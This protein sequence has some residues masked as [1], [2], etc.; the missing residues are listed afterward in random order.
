MTGEFLVVGLGRFGRDLALNLAADRQS[1]LAVDRNRERV[2]GVA[3]HV[4]AALVADT[5]DESVLAELHPER[6]TCAV[7]AIG[8]G[9]IESSI[10]TC[11]L[12]HQFQVPRLVARAASALHS[13]VLRAVGVDEVISPEADMAARLARRL[14]HPNI[15]DQIELGDQVDL[16]EIGLPEAFADKSLIELDVRRKYGV[17]VVAIRRQGKILAGF[18][19][20]ERLQSG[21]V[22]LV[23]GPRDHIS[24]LAA[25]A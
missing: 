3:D 25:M 18:A 24:R 14:A 4:D 19:G 21:D 17:S 15:F 20:S 23:L 12:L 16:A 10:L 5:T 11:S 1:V 13:R 6:M 7:V 8:G 2:Q 22:L 9:N